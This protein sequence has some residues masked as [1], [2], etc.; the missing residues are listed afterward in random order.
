M[1][2]IRDGMDQRLLP[3]YW[4]GHQIGDGHEARRYQYSERY[5][6]R[7]DYSSQGI[8]K[9]ILA[10][11][12]LLPDKTIARAFSEGEEFDSHAYT[13]GTIIKF[14]TETLR[15]TKPSEAYLDH[16]LWGVIMDTP[17]DP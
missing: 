12:S 4:G 5:F 9:Q 13:P 16:E 3:E 11:F 1:R 10:E 7:T 17:K 15:D 8:A 2:E 6:P 14:R